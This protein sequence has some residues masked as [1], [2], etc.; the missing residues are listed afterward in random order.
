M[1]EKK[2]NHKFDMAGH[3]S[4]STVICLQAKFY[5]K[6]LNQEDSMRYF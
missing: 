3:I 1:A 4:N 2:K 6:N 5:K